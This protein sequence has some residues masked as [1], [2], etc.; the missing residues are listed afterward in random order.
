MNERLKVG[1]VER[2]ITPGTLFTNWVT[3]EI[4]PGVRDPLKFHVTVIGDG[5]DWVVLGAFD[6]LEIRKSFT[7]YIRQQI[8]EKYGILEERVLLNASHSHSA[9]R[10]PYGD[11]EIGKKLFAK[12]FAKFSKEEAYWDWAAKVVE[13]FIAA[14][15]EALEKAKPA[16]G[17]IRR[18]FAGDYVFNRRPLGADGET[19]TQF[20]PQN[21]YALG[22]GARYGNTDKGLVCL[23][24]LSGDEVL[25][26]FLSLACHTVAI[27]PKD[28]RVSADWAGALRDQVVQR[29]G[30]IA[31][32]FQGCAGDQVPMQRG[33]EI[34]Q[35]MSE[36]LGERLEQSKELAHPLDLSGI[37][38]GVTELGLPIGV[39]Q[40]EDLHGKRCEMTEVQVVR[41]GEVVIVALPGEILIDVGLEIQRRSPFS[42]TICLGYSNSHGTGYCGLPHEFARGG[43][44]VQKS[45]S[46]GA[47]ECGQILI[48]AAVRLLY[49]AMDAF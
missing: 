32:F 38:S 35:E 14:V 33:A 11:K 8:R 20:T 30:G 42:H 17:N 27:Y 31:T 7:G 45:V 48:E 25:G 18:I 37:W 12:K 5:E 6:V 9:P 16:G 23:Q 26:S 43:Y 28:A 34:A 40:Y 47:P 10:C 41:I 19:I 21:R 39:G 49:D 15:G 46:L 24:F 2:D 13:E 3:G 1:I 4:Y 29:E 36:T 44:E 22:A